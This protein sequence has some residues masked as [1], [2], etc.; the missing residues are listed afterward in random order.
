MKA[1]E[2]RIGNYLQDFGGNI[3]QVI[4][5]TKDKI[6]LESPITLTEEWLLK[7]GFEWNI[8]HQAIHKED[9]GFDLNSLY[10]GGYSLTTFKKG[11]TIV[12]FIQ[13]V[14]Q[15]QNIYVALTGEELTL[16]K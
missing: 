10:Y 11:T 2:L 5:L 3:A 12:C 8:T 15:L 14:H 16:Q 13:Y 6:I 9:F 7:L 1:Q 4:H